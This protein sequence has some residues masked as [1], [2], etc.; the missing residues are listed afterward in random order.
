MRLRRDALAGAAEFMLAAESLARRTPGLVA[1]VGVVQVAPGAG[2]VIPGEVAHTLDVRHAKD[3]I[4]KRAL[5]QLGRM[6]AR[7]ASQRK[8]KVGWQR[9][10]NDAAVKCAPG[11]SGRLAQSVRAVQGR[12]LELVS[13]AGHDAVVLSHLTE[14]AMLFVRCRGGL[15]HHPDEY[16]SAKDL[17]VALRV[18]V[19]FLERLGK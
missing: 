5:R 14:V 15:S 11:L 6:A 17:G 9:T 10:Q 2:N 3:S 4:R 18:V 16:A 19:D 7:I 8:L 12:S 1:T 13:G